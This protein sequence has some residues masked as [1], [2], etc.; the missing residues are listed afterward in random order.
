LGRG[1]TILSNILLNTWVTDFT[2][3]FKAISREAKE[4]VFPLSIING[5]G[6][7]AEVLFLAQ[8]LSFEIVE[9][10]VLWQDDRQSKVKLM[11]DLPQT[12]MELIKIRIIHSKHNPSFNKSPVLATQVS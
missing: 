11:K 7:D 1:F 2:C 10:A 4:A 8:K 6:Y 9:K 5:W 12:L 3:G